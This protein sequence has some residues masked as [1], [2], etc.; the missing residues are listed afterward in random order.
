MSTE[1][2]KNPGSPKNVKIKKKM[3]FFKEY[4][5]FFEH[6]ITKNPRPPREY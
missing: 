2:K 4:K 5:P 3:Y 6:G 1:L